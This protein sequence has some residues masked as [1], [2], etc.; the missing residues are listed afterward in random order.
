MLLRGFLPRAILTAAG[1]SAIVIGCTPAITD[2]PVWDGGGGAAS[3]TATGTGGDGFLLDAGGGGPPPA[4]AGDLCGNEF[5][6]ITGNPPN[7]YFVL[8]RSGSMAASVA[9]GGTRYT[10]VQHAAASL[11]NHLEALIR[12]GATVFPGVSDQCSAGK[13][14][15]PTAYG[16]PYG[17]DLSTKAVTPGGGTPTAATLQSVLPKLTALPGKT[18]VVLATDGGPNCNG[19]A[20]CTAADCMENIEGCS[21]GDTCCALNQNCCAPGGPAGPLNCVDTDPSVAAVTAIAQAGIK[22]FVIG[23]PGSQTYEKVLAKMALA[24]GA[25][26]PAYPFYYKVDDLATIDSV[27]ASAAG[28]AIPCDFQLADTP[29]DPSLTNVYLDQTI[30]LQDPVDGWTWT[31]PDTITLHGVACAK[32]HSGQVGNVQI[33]SGCPTEQAK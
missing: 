15:F 3:S 9:G 18:V 14:V 19:A 11:A 21:Q 8:D 33:V 24:G 20:A 26:L 29:Q 12:V 28:S 31:A 23:I 13:E 25:A 16:N 10:A 32:L 27:L 5:H 6:Q 7:V 22:V 17:F 1:A 4:D 30:V 2:Y